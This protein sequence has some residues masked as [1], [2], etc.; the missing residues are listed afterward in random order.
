M[1]SIGKPLQS[2]MPTPNRD[3]EHLAK[4]RD[5]YAEA[6]RIPTQQRIAD[7]IGFSKPAARKFL[8]RIEAEGFITRTP[9]DDAW[10]PAYRF[11]ERALADATVQA[12]HPV[13]TE[14][15]AAEPFFVDD[16]IVRQP[17][18]TVMVTVKGESMTEAGINDGD[19]AVVERDITAKVGD[20]VVAIVDNEFTLKELGSERGQFVL[21]PHNKAFQVIRPKGQLEI[22]GVLVGI[23]R[24]YRT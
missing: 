10:I 8:E 17:S 7:L 5:Y 6:R 13:A 22:Y 15:V 19:V 1:V 24:R 11:F 12:G 14:G 20:F 9:D 3:T 23:I 2:I 21:K 18:K 4:L 16:Y